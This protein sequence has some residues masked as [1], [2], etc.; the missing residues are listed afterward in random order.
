MAWG[1]EQRKKGEQKQMIETVY[2]KH[3][4]ESLKERVSA[5][6]K[7]CV[8]LGIGIILLSISNLLR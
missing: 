6:E 4:V 3:D 2:L 5:L 7:I 8:M 1:M